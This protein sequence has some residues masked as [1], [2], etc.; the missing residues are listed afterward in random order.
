MKKYRRTFEVEIP[1]EENCNNCPLYFEG[2][3]GYYCLKNFPKYI[4][5]ENY[6]NDEKNDPIKNK[7]CPNLKGG[8]NDDNSYK[9]FQLAS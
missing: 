3:G 6:T 7:D 4:E 2:N 5:I 9:T 8:I 1:D